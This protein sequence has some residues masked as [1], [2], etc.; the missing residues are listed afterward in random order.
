MPGTLAADYVFEPKVWA[1]H[2]DAH[3]DKHLV[4][5]AL[6]VPDKTLVT[7][8]GL[9]VSFPY[10]KAIGQAEKPGETD[11]LTPDK[12]SD[13]S[14]SATVSEI[15]KAVS[16]SKTSFFKSAASQERITNEAQT[17]MG[18]VIAEQVDA[19]IITEINTVGNY[20]TGYTA[21]AAAAGVCTVANLFRGK[22]TAFGDKQDQVAAYVIH[23]QHL[24]SSG[25]DSISGFMKADANDPLWGT[26]GFIGRILKAAVIVTDQC[27]AGATVDG[28]QT[29]YAYAFKANPFGFMVKQEM[30][31]EMDKDI[32]AREIILASTQWSAVK[33]FHGKVSANDKRIC[34]ML[35]TTELAA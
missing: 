22:V 6:A 4:F 10:F 14:F 8:P 12:L 27:P 3:F 20:T 11:V 30:D 2:V 16:F 9:T 1:D 19:D 31:L 23:S 21:S 28:K 34:R 13:D 5:G 7:S 18:R 29:F 33:A 35:F 26:P 24:L 32:L 25:I 17:Q 15:A